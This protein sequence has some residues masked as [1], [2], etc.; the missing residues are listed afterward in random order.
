[1]SEGA[2]VGDQVGSTVPFS[3]GYFDDPY[4]LKVA[5][6][7]VQ[8]IETAIYAEDGLKLSPMT[9]T[10]RQHEPSGPHGLNGYCDLLMWKATVLP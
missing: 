4:R 5:K 9:F 2:K 3:D 10:V 8:A 7:A 1:M 6:E